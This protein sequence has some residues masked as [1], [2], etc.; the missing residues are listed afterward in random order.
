[1][2]EG[3]M[4]VFWRGP[5]KNLIVSTRHVLTDLYYGIMELFIY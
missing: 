5:I 1:M 2:L 4:E 3:V